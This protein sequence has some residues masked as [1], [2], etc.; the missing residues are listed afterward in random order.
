VG[1]SLGVDVGEFEDGDL[2]G[3]EV[4]DLVGEIVGVDEVGDCVGDCVGDR[5]FSH[6]LQ[7]DAPH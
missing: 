1:D 3:D 4:G 2:V 6:I 7:H 5:E